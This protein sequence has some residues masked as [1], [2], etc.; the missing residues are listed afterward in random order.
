MSHVRRVVL[1]CVFV[2]V[3]SGFGAT[4]STPLRISLPPVLEA[5]PIAFAEEW[6]LFDE[7]GLAVELIGMANDENRSLAFRGGSLDAVMSDVTSAVMDYDMDHSITVVGAA[8]STPQ[9]GALRIALLSQ[10]GRGPSTLGEP[11]A[12][13]QYI[14]VMWKTDEEYLLDQLF[15]SLGLREPRI[16]CFNDRILLAVLFAGGSPPLAVLPEPYI[17]YLTTYVPASGVS[18]QITMLS[19]FSDLAAPPRV[20]AFRRDFLEQHS[21]DAATFLRVYDAAVDRMN[22][23]PRD[24]IINVGLDAVIGLFFPGTDRSLIQSQTLDAMSIPQFERPAPLSQ[25][26]FTSV[27]EWMMDKYYIRQCPSFEELTDFSL[28]P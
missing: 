17:T 21:A 8:G 23:T 12:P 3:G 6:G 4:A 14:G 11:L 10:V 5:L 24:E 18:I 27:T 15:R 7:A 22:A 26:I 13:S 19:D 25:G 2:A 20:I 9:S 16:T 28:L 1:L